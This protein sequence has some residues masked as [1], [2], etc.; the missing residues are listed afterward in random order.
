MVSPLNDANAAETLAKG[1]KNPSAESAITAYVMRNI[2]QMTVQEVAEKLGIH[3]SNVRKKVNYGFELLTIAAVA[4]YILEIPESVWRP[5]YRAGYRSKEQIKA[6]VLN[7]K[8]AVEHER[9]GNR[10]TINGIG[11]AKLF[12]LKEWLGIEVGE[13]KRERGER[14]H[15]ETCREKWWKTGRKPKGFG[16]EQLEQDNVGRVLAVRT[17]MRFKHNQSTVLVI[18]RDRAKYSNFTTLE[19]SR[20]LGVSV[21]YLRN[22]VRIGKISRNERNL[23]SRKELLR[24]AAYNL[25]GWAIREKIEREAIEET[26]EESS[27]AGSDEGG[28][29]NNAENNEDTWGDMVS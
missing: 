23:F 11:R 22:E 16:L 18:L 10:G 21:S 17:S 20:I 12:T 3:V 9:F 13:S 1:F 29:S 26:T 2:K 6:D 7:G 25:N 4:P 5:L 28:S 19:A 24:W 27:G 15:K 8:I 14:G